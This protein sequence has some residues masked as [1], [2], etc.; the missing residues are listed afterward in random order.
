MPARSVNRREGETRSQR[1]RR[2]MM[3]LV[4][5]V[6]NINETVRAC[7]IY[8]RLCMAHPNGHTHM[9]I[10]VN[11]LGQIMRA[12]KEWRKV[13]LSKNKYAWKRLE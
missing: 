9:P 8:E 1:K 4:R 12:Q 13:V 10:N 2:N 6:V 5:Q 3:K 7:A 11:S